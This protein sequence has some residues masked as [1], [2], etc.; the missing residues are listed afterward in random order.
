MLQNPL[1]LV[2]FFKATLRLLEVLGVDASSAGAM[3]DRILDVEHFMIENEFQRYTRSRSGIEH[4]VDHNRM[5]G[6]IV[7]S[8]GLTR[9]AK[10][11]AEIRAG[12]ESVEVLEVEVFE[13][14]HEI[15][16]PAFGRHQ[17]FASSLPAK[18]GNGCSDCF[19]RKVFAVQ[20]VVFFGDGPAVELGNEDECERLQNRFRRGLK[21]IADAHFEV[22]MFQLNEAVGVGE[23][24]EPQ[25]NA[26]RCGTRP[27]DAENAQKERCSGL[28]HVPV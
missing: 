25:V 3:F 17:F 11:P 23:L 1:R 2:I 8:Q 16:V 6:V 12:H 5:V 20:R 9:R 4:A 19:G 14:L 27:E 13:D 15:V 10:A 18:S 26:R 28:R 7:V 24:G 22:P 21:G